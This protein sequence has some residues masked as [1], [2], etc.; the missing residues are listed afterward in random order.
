M[1]LYE[2]NTTRIKY[3]QFNKNVRCPKLFLLSLNSNTHVNSV[4]AM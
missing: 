2:E 1:K 4:N 3:I